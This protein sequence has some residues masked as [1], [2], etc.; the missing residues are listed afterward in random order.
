M[1]PNQQLWNPTKLPK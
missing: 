1:P